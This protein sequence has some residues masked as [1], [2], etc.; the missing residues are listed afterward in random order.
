MY[1]DTT[2]IAPATPHGYGGISVIRLSGP[3][4]LKIIENNISCNSEALQ[5]N[6]RL[7]ITTLLTNNGGKEIDQIIATYFISPNSYTGEDVLEISCHG[8]PAIV[9]DIISVCTQNGAEMAEPGEFTKR[10]FLNGKIDLIQAEAVGELINAKSAEGAKLN[11]KIVSGGLSSELSS[12]KDKLI[13]LLAS[14]EYSL[15]ISEEELGVDYFPGVKETIDNITSSVVSLLDGHRQAR[16]LT[17]GASVVIA[18]PPNVGKST[19]LNALSKT[20]RAIVSSEPGTTRDPLDVMLLL[21]G[22][23]VRLIDT[24]GLRDTKEP[25]EKEGVARTKKHINESDLSILISSPDVRGI[26]QKDLGENFISIL[27]KSDLL[28]PGF[29]SNGFDCVVSAKHNDRLDDLMILIKSRLSLSPAISD[30]APLTSA[31]QYDSLLDVHSCLVRCGDILNSKHNQLELLAADVRSA[32]ESL[33]VILGKTTTDEI[34]DSV[35]NSFC[36]GK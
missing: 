8:N 34:L 10:A 22:V 2:I 5:N 11:H 6:P 18:G 17:S 27:N 23:P 28:D 24:A 16:L 15:D 36:V 14:F 3:D 26:S 13:T 19:L 7:A 32:I 29:D 30:I 31:R 4:S 35:F 25:I 9:Q 12:L 21:D 33:D 20:D 1:A